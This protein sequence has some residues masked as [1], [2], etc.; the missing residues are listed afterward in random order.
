MAVMRQAPT[1][2]KCGEEVKG[3]YK[4]VNKSFGFV[5]DTFLF[6]NYEG[7]VCKNEDKISK[8]KFT[9]KELS[10]SVQFG[11]WLLKNC[12]PVFEGEFL[13]WSY[14]EGKHKDTLELYLIFKEEEL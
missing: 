7:H 1:C 6:W 14:G 5:G 3:V 13:T 8:K 9:P 11:R 2:V 12:S 4:K 10:D